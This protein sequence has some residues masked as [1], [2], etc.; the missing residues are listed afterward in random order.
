M[1][2]KKVKSI[3]INPKNRKRIK[4][5]IAITRLKRTVQR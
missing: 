2:H 4:R 3:R 1:E 5:K